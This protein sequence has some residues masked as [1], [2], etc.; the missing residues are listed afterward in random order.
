MTTQQGELRDDEIQE[1]FAYLDGELSEEAATALEV[2][3]ADNAGLARRFEELGRLDERLRRGHV[4][5]V[6]RAPRVW[7]T[8]LV[9]AAAVV[10]LVFFLGG[11]GSELPPA[12]RVAVLPGEATLGDYQ[13]LIG[14]PGLVQPTERGGESDPEVA[15]K[16][17]VLREAARQAAIEALSQGTF[18][19]EGGYYYIPVQVEE[20]VHVIVA[21]YPA[22]NKAWLR[23]PPDDQDPL[24]PGLHFLPKYPILSA[25]GSLEFEKGYLIPVGVDRVE[26]VLGVTRQVEADETDLT[27]AAL[28]GRSPAEFRAWLEERGYRCA[29]LT[30][31]AP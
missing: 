22:G 6:S 4:E 13:A 12:L 15:A 16:M 24:Q 19:T 9:A 31:V 29:Q 10:A 21:E 18:H 20:P 14:H 11:G 26:V 3:L 30:V 8:A 28:R 17:E 25:A 27:Q 1:L 23:E 2:R 7:T 5:G